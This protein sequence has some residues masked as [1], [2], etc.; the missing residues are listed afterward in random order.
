M[1]TLF[2]MLAA[3][4]SVLGISSLVASLGYTHSVPLFFGGLGWLCGAWF[5]ARVH[6]GASCVNQC[7]GTKYFGKTEATNAVIFTKWIIF[8]LPLLPVRSFVVHGVNNVDRSFLT[9]VTTYKLT[10]LPGIG[11]S[12]PSVRKTIGVTI[13]LVALIVG[14][15]YVMS[16]SGAGSKH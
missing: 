12:W 10:R 9:T 8:L 14:L 4:A 16:L 1:V 6:D 5:I 7:A 13:L 11:L 15:D 2:S 3:V